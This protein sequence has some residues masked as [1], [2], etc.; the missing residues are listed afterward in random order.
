MAQTF[1]RPGAS[2]LLDL[3][4]GGKGWEIQIIFYFYKVLISL[5]LKL[6]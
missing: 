3:G 4:E 6:I 2:T 1:Q 5:K